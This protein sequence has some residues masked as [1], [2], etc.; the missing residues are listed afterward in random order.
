VHILELVLDGRNDEAAEAM[1]KH[2]S[3]LG[4]LKAPSP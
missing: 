4:P 1:R 2:L 3:A